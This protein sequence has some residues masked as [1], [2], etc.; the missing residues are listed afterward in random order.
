MYSINSISIKIKD[1][2]L[3]VL[4]KKKKNTQANMHIE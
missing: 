2:E 1:N 3:V 4:G